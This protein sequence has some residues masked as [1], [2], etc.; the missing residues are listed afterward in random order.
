MQANPSLF[1]AKVDSPAVLRMDNTGHEEAAQDILKI[2]EMANEEIDQ[3][4]KN[5]GAILSLSFMRSDMWTF[6]DEIMDSRHYI[7]Y[8][9]CRVEEK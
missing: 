8:C 7:T 3:D 2:F 9:E 4:E 5:L 1:A 6:C